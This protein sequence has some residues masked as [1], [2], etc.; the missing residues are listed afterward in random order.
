MLHHRIKVAP[1]NNMISQKRQFGGSHPLDDD[2]MRVGLG[3]NYGLIAAKGYGYSY[4][5]EVGSAPPRPSRGLFE[6]R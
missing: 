1:H 4:S 3:L 5:I 2:G 6:G